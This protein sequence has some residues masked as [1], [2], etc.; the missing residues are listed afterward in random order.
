MKIK[1]KQEREYEYDEN[2]SIFE[3]KDKALKEYKR[4]QPEIELTLPEEIKAKLK[5]YRK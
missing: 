3:N 5:S 2:L 4:V 1:I